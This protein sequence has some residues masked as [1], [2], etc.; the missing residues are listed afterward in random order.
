MRAL[1]LAGGRGTRLL[2]HTAVLPKPLVPVGELPVMEILLRQLAQHGIQDVI[3]SVG[4]LAGLLEAYF[5]DG[6][7]L[8]VRVR[9]QHET[10]P[11]GTAG[12]LRLVDDMGTSEA[13]LVLNGDLLTDLDFRKFVE[14]YAATAPAIQ[15]G[16]YRRLEQIDL[17]VLD[18][19][20]G[21]EVTGYREKPSHVYDVSMGV[22]IVSSQAGKLVPAE[23]R[24][25]MPDLVTAALR[26]GQRVTAFRHEGM[27]LD[28]G[29]LDDHRRATEMAAAHPALFQ[30]P[31]RQAV[32]P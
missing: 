10:D 26:C 12:P 21:G 15:I 25:D 29:R 4:Y 14:T 6:S 22:Y 1:V 32:E 17:G 8:G 31:L 3:V 16:T 13:L 7:R 18:V 30:Q 19:N 23:G 27:W 28:I 9:Y 20:G 2:P 11:R 5:M 24:F